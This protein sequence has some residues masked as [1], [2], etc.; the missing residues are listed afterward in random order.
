[1]RR[2][3]RQI[4][5]RPVHLPQHEK[6]AENQDRAEQKTDGNNPPDALLLSLGL[7][8]RSQWQTLFYI[9]RLAVGTS[10]KRGRLLPWDRGGSLGR[11]RLRSDR[12]TISRGECYGLAA[13]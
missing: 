5:V 2:A 7:L 10:A 9:V 1:D 3:L 8:A 12:S 4:H 11:R 6:G 13:A